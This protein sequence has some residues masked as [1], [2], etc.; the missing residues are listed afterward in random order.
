[1]RKVT[2]E[3][4][5]R[6]TGLS[7]GTVSRALNDRPDISTR[8]KQRVLE[9]CQ[10]LR[11]VPSHA[12]RSLATGRNYAVAAL[13]DDLRS[14]FASSF[15]RG[16]IDRA[17]EA[18][19]VVHVIETGSDPPPDGLRTVSP[20]RIDAALNAVALK[21]RVASQLRQTV[22]NRALTSC[23]PLEGVPCDVLT[24]DQTEAGRM[25]ARFLV[26]SG[27][28]QLLY[29]RRPGSDADDERLLGF[30]EV[31]RA[32]HVDPETASVTDPE[33]GT[34]GPQLKRAEA[35]VAADDF[36]AVSIMLLCERVGRRPGEDLAVIGHGNEPLAASI[37]PP[38]TSVDLNGEEIGR[39]AMETVLQ[40]IGRERMDAPQH[41]RIAPMLIQR[42]STRQVTP[43]D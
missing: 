28:R 6:E 10:K 34:L 26:R 24:P 37:Q 30:H 23:W 8:T 25:V 2:I 42:A 7:R 39:R 40:R 11:Y 9:A 15:L 17:E 19:Y 38:L 20:E 43:V 35:V 1:M 41:S 22:G 36:L 31:C 14:A 4:I 29:V 18:H 13:V 5:S 3:D 33:L 16:V 21:P 32:H 27:L 12:A